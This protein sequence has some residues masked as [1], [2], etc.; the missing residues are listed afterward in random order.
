MARSAILT[1]LAIASVHPTDAAAQQPDATAGGE[2]CTEGYISSIDVDR[3]NVFDPESTGI[4]LLAWTLRFANLFHIRTADS[5]VRRELLFE[6]GDCL[7]PFLVSESQRLLYSYAFVD[8]AEITY[9]PDGNGGQKVQVTTRD[10]WSLEVDAGVT[11]DDGLNLEKFQ[12]TEENFL[13]QGIFAEFT[14]RERREARTQGFRLF[15]PRLFG[16][17]DAS[18]GAGRDRPGNFFNQSIRYP[19][20]GETGE[21]SFREG[22]DRATRF[23]SYSTGGAEAFTNVLVPSFRQVVELSLAKRLGEEGRSFLVGA[24]LTHDI[25]RF[26]RTPEIT[27]LDDFDN[28][29]L[30]PGP[31]PTDMAEQLQPSGATRLSLHV[32]TRRYRYEFYEGID[33]LRD[34]L[35]VSL[36]FYAGLSVGKGM[37]LFVPS[38]VPG[39]DDYFGRLH[40]SFGAPVGSTLLHGGFTA[41]ARHDEGEFRDVLF[42]VDVVGYLRNQALP[43][44]TLFLRAS[45][46]GG[47]NTYL[48]YQLSLGGREGVRSLKEDLFPG[49]R[50]TKFVVEERYMFPWP[51]RGVADIGVTAFWDVGRVSAGDAPYGVDSDWKSALGF[52][53]RIGLPS[54][55]RNVF[56]TDV[57]FPVGGGDPLFRFTFE[58]NLLRE[59]FFTP[60]V[61]RSRRFNLGAEHF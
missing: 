18:I 42:D 14:H 48:P 2:V 25:I 39:L 17:T 41:E 58:L 5:F 30:F 26:P 49:G 40:A 23:F 29:L 45:Y 28:P 27:L 37:S 43:G 59:G 11:Y 8:D 24:T 52:G 21:Y 55:T 13:G 36:G 51:R 15:T 61:A 35:Q 9:E 3:A 50:M 1:A 22:I 60:D 44:S 16:R 54:R 34:R 32:G 57:A 33:G 47:W 4:G 10:R 19:F 56:R 6:E 53:F 12:V 38:D 7:S 31:L 20:V 46:G